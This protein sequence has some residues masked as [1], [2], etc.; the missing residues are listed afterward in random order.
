MAALGSGGANS[1]DSKNV[2][3]SLPILFFSCHFAVGKEFLHLVDGRVCFQGPD[4]GPSEGGQ[5]L[6]WTRGGG[7][8]P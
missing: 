6:V 1:N 4:Q 7:G 2:R 8:H 3:P 5:P